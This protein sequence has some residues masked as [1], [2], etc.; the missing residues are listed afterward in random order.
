VQRG[1]SFLSAAQFVEA[2]QGMKRKVNKITLLV[3][4]MI[5]IMAAVAIVVLTN[6]DR[7]AVKLAPKKQ[8]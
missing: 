7:I 5:L 8:A 4:T 2:E 6:T 1:C 3:I